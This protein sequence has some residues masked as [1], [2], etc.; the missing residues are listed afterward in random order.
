ML[1]KVMFWLFPKVDGTSLWVFTMWAV[2]LGLLM[3]PVAFVAAVFFTL[4]KV[5]G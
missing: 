2:L 5:S 4:G 1:M 3:I